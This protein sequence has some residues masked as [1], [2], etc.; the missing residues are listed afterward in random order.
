[1]KISPPDYISKI[2]PYVAGKPIEELEREYGVSN[3]VKLAS[4]E[5]P[6]G[7]SPLAVEAVCKESLKLHR[8]P[9][10]Q[11]YELIEKLKSKF[12]LEDLAVVLG[13]GSDDIISMVCKAYVGIDDKVIIPD[14]GFLL[15]EISALAQGAELIKIPLKEIEIDLDAMVRASDLDTKL[16]FI[17]N[18]NNPTGTF[19]TEEML[20][21][22]ME[23]IPETTIVFM[24]EA[25]M[26]F[27]VEG[28][29][30]WK[31]I[32]KYPNIITSR[33][34]SKAYG[35]AGLRIGYGVMHEDVAAVLNKVRQ[36]FNANLLA[37]AGAVAALNDD[38][39]LDR[40]R[41]LIVDEREKLSR[42][43]E[44]L[45]FHSFKSSA[46]FLLVDMG[47][48]ADEIYEK[49][50]YQGVIARSMSSYGYPEFLR[51]SIGLEYENIRF[52]DSLKKILEEP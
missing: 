40:T 46:N 12:C 30:S 13:N 10:S 1:V 43:L 21:N 18:P 50:L 5:N 14:P 44:Q 51:V 27:A 16:I 35:L 33:T 20:V 41:D 36:P 31:F 38:V 19:I 52:I 29:A 6:L 4:N 8:Y 45:G 15:Y 24:D 25:Y 47:R 28:F 23:K 3:A 17:T 48:S 32:E 2:V 11:G 26:E 42:K 7:P 22:F 39:F 37:Q 34:F 9:D 49:L